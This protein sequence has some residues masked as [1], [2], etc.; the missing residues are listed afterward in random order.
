MSTE[1]NS[2]ETTVFFW[3]N[4]EERLDPLFYSTSELLSKEGIQ[5]LPVHP[6]QISRLA[7]LT[8]SAHIIL[9]CSTRRQAEYSA[10]ARMVVPTLGLLLQQ[11]KLSLFHFSSFHKLNVGPTL[12]KYENY[13]FFKYPLNLAS[14]CAKLKKFHQLKVTQAQKWPGGKRAKVSGLAV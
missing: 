5:L 9:L 7:A 11:E 6:S 13:F 14:V 12:P 1:V 10:F 3:I 8:E 4:L 2:L